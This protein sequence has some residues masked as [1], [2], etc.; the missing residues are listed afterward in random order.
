MKEK[1]SI[2]PNDQVIL[3]N[4]NM[5]ALLNEKV[6]LHV[7]YNT[8]NLANLIKAII[9]S[10]IGIFIF[11]IP[12]TI[13]ENNAV[14]MVQLINAIKGS[15]SDYLKWIVLIICGALSITFTIAKIK[16][17]GSLAKFHEK[18]GWISGIL[19]YL[20]AIFAF[21]LVFQVGPAQVLNEDVGGLSIS[22]AGSTLLT[23]SIAGWLV[24][25]LIE[26]G[27]L[28]FLG[29]LLEPI[30][31]TVF[32]V[33]GQSAVDALSSFVAA[34]AVGVFITNKLYNENVYT[35]K[36]ACCIATNF[37]VV[38]LGFFALLVSITDT[39]EMYSVVVLSSL[40][41]SFILAAIVIRIP[42]LSKKEDRYKNGVEQ[43]AEMR[44]PGKYSLGVFNKNPPA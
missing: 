39:V 8:L 26:F 11:F 28:E 37:S 42:P 21:M 4:D 22:L 16:K 12:I 14:P 2:P 43:T 10:G 17:E 7:D 40:I 24:T 32:K 23:V 34:P 38:S 5:D 29:T 44:K 25:F 9:F 6:G 19:Y 30:M 15:L 1:N 18:D 33:P 35:K 31:R 41:I 36:E 3:P 27:I 13:G 20:S